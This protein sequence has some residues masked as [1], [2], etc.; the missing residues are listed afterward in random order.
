MNMLTEG[1]VI[2]G[3]WYDSYNK[4]TKF[5]NLTGQKF[6]TTQ[7][8]PFL[9]QTCQIKLFSCRNLHFLGLSLWHLVIQKL[10]MITI[11]LFSIVSLLLAKRKQGT[12]DPSA[13]ITWIVRERCQ[14]DNLLPLS[15]NLVS[16]YSQLVMVW[17]EV[18]KKF[19]GSE[20]KAK[21]FLQR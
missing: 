11:N 16:I 9:R 12:D 15:P 19:T 17:P 2:W 1:Q 14:R 6:H 3:I 5:H 7:K 18:D 20:P 10:K 8:I 13:N 21:P 4:R